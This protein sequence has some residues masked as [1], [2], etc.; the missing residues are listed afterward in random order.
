MD[1]FCEL[2][3]EPRFINGG[4]F[5]DHPRNCHVFKDDPARCS[6]LCCFLLCLTVA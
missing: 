1:G 6:L 2:S 4:K 5:L 3:N